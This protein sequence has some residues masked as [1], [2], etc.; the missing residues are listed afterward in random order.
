[1]IIYLEGPDGSGKSTLA[2]SIYKV[3]LEENIDVERFAERNISTHPLK[4][5][6]ISFDR[7]IDELTYMAEDNMVHILDRGPISDCIYRMFDNFDPVGKLEDYIKLF[8]KFVDKNQL[9]LIYARTKAAEKAMKERGDE[10]PIALN[11][12]K[13]LS[14]A[15][16]LIMGVISYS[17]NSDMLIYDF[18]VDNALEEATQRIL[19][20]IKEK[21]NKG[22]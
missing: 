10:N 11:R 2:N 5:D 21:L 20:T 16:D 15:Y 6:R 1:M 7:L 9:I 13:E 22:A 17:I 14:K 3:C 8:K 12:H 18:T 19:N 4:P